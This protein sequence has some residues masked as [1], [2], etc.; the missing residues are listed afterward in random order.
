MYIVYL[1]IFYLSFFHPMYLSP[2]PCYIYVVITV[3][4][5]FTICQYWIDSLSLFCYLTIC[6]NIQL[7]ATTYN[8]RTPVLPAVMIMKNFENRSLIW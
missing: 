6:N 1:S 5:E 8:H 3:F 2:L 7:Y 4:F